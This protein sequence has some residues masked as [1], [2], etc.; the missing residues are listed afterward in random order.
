[1]VNESKIDEK[2][3]HFNETVFIFVLGVFNR[4]HLRLFSFL[5]FS[6]SIM[7]SVWVDFFCSFLLAERTKK[8]RR[9]ISFFCFDRY[10]CQPHQKWWNTC[11]NDSYSF[12]LN[13]DLLK[14]GEISNIDFT[15]V[16][17][18]KKQ[19]EMNENS[20][21]G[22][23][24]NAQM[25]FD[26]NDKYFFL[27]SLASS[28]RLWMI[29]STMNIFQLGKHSNSKNENKIFV[30]TVWASI[31]VSFQF[32]SELTEAFFFFSSLFGRKNCVN[33]IP[34]HQFAKQLLD[35]SD[36]KV[37]R[38]QRISAQN[39]GHKFDFQCAKL[40]MMW[41]IAS[42]IVSAQWN[43]ISDKENSWFDSCAISAST[44]QGSSVVIEIFV[45]I[46]YRHIVG[47]VVKNA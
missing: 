26:K 13:F 8:L 42:H 47:H 22:E 40:K 5:F 25:A 29:Q 28:C 41:R 16:D 11:A 45:H 10:C 23:A 32:A 14:N 4:L 35:Y 17:Q 3:K 19:N 37:L 38:H 15:S 7:I 9:K 27:D 30:D 2:K 44:R 18:W 1:M 43:D 39:C 31:G 34:F 36:N 20:R 24:K 6:H 21:F 46:V 12:H 33:K